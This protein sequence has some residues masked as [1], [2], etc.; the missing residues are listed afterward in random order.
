MQIVE[1]V[2]EL[3]NGERTKYI[4]RAPG[5]GDGVAVIALNDKGEILVQREYSYPPNEIMYQLPGGGVENG[6]DIEIAANRE[7]SEESGYQAKEVKIIGSSYFN[8]RR[9]DARQ[10]VAVC[11]GL[12][13]RSLPKDAE[14]F[15]ESEWMS[16][17]R[18][19][20]LIVEGEISNMNMLAALQL[21]EA[22]TTK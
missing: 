12:S 4:R 20:E 7:L 14:E 2:V 5:A 22:Q 16:F 19:R 13:E 17:A 10:H 11:T 18:V 1:D 9:S 3:P 6:E 21:F 15:I 8:N